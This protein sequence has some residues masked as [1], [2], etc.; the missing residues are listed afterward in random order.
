VRLLNWL[1]GK[2]G[3]ARGAL[4]E[5]RPP[6]ACEQAPPPGE[7]PLGPDRPSPE[8]PVAPAVARGGS[9]PLGADS[10]PAPE[11]GG[12]PGLD[13]E[14][15]NLRRWKE[16]GQVRAWVEGHHGQWGHLEW[17]ALLESLRQ[18]AYWPM[19][20]DEVGNALEEMKREWPRR[21]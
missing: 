5:R 1:F 8:V 20:P 12:R 10:R 9:P 6:R 7:A 13:A 2:K 14:A 16:S 17:L 18:S 15:E 3:T 21:D 19:H 4:P 11:D